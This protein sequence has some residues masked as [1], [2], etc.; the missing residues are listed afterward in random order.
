MKNFT[1][2]LFMLFVFLQLEA[3]VQVGYGNSTVNNM[4]ISSCYT[5]SYSQQIYLAS[6][7]SVSG[8]IS[9]LSFY[10]KSAANSGNN[11][12]KN[13]SIYLGTTTKSN[14]TGNT[15][16]EPYSSLTEVFVGDVVFPETEGWMTIDLDAPFVYDGIN[17]LLVAVDE[18]SL[19]ASCTIT[20]EG[21]TATNS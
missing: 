5:Y 1:L 10:Y 16:W 11:N 20:F 21:F 13:W 18:N 17:N 12:S 3:Q 8:T 15:D 9:Q 19:G 4:P 2:S 6:E 7:V 14:F